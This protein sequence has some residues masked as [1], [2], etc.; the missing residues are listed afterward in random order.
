MIERVFLMKLNVKRHVHFYVASY[1]SNPLLEDFLFHV[2]HNTNP[3]TLGTL[4]SSC[5]QILTRNIIS[6]SLGIQLNIGPLLHETMII[7]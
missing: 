5:F 1:A 7:E 2:G 6:I 3:S 4:D